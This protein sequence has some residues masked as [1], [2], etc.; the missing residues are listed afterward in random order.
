MKNTLWLKGLRKAILYGVVLIGCFFGQTPA[1]AYAV[2]CSNCATFYQQMFEYAEAVH[3]TLNTAEQLKTEIQQY[4]D[5]IKQGMSLPDKLFQSVTN[6]IQKVVDVYHAAKTLGRNIGNID[7]DFRTQFSGYEDYLKS[8]GKASSSLPNR[9]EAWSKQGLDNARTALKAVGLNVSTF[10][11]E[12]S[13][14]NQMVSRSQNAT[15]RLQAIQAGNEIAAQN[16]QQL[17][18]LRDL[19]ATQILLQGN[20]MAQYQER[21]SM[22]DAVRQ[23][24]RKGVIINNGPSKAF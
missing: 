21:L 17:Q 1:K 4:N 15:G 14:L 7:E 3:T 10:L 9:Y 18:K 20:F 23:Q 2:Y 5:M 22:D 13:L 19:V 16:V 11:G 12:D 24:R 6:D 8:I